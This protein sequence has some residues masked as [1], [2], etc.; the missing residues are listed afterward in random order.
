MGVV[1]YRSRCLLVFHQVS[2]H[3]ATL[4]GFILALAAVIAV[5]VLAALHSDTES[6]LVIL[7]A[8]GGAGVGGGAGVAV[9]GAVVASPDKG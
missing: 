7:S 8:I 9:Q 4:Y 5:T 2:A 1:A 3:P 6:V